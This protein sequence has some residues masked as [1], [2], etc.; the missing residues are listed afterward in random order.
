M[1]RRTLSP[2]I[3]DTNALCHVT[4]SQRRVSAGFTVLYFIHRRS[5]IIDRRVRFLITSV[6]WR[7]TGVRIL[8]TSGDQ[9]ILGEVIWLFRC[10]LQLDAV[11]QAAVEFG[12][13]RGLLVYNRSTLALTT[14]HCPVH[15]RCPSLHGYIRQKSCL[16]ISRLNYGN[17]VLIGLPIHLVRCLPSAQH[18]AEQLISKLRRF[19]HKTD[20]LVNSHWLHFP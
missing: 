8:P 15:W 20:A 16:V 14:N 18:A 11:K 5:G 13:V 7:H 4:C 17:G 2:K 10:H 19:D 1:Q 6:R 12:Q 3:E 9:R